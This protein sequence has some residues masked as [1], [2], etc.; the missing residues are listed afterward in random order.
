MSETLE[1]EIRSVIYRNDESGYAVVRVEDTGGTLVTAVGCLPHIAPGETLTAQGRWTSHPSHGEQFS[2]HKVRRRLPDTRE[3]VLAYLS[4]G[5]IRGVGKATALLIVEEFGAEALQVLERDPGQLA[6]VK[7]LSASRAKQISESFAR[8]IGIRKLMEL[9]AGHGIQPQTAL[10]LTQAYGPAAL[11]RITENPYLMIEPEFGVEF[12]LADA[13]AL[14]GGMEYDDLRRRQA[15]LLYQLYFNMEVGHTYLPHKKL[16]DST[17]Q[18]L[19]EEYPAVLAPALEGLLSKRR[20]MCEDGTPEASSRCYLHELYAAETAVAAFFRQKIAQQPAAAA[21]PELTGLLAEIEAGSGMTYAP[22]QRKAVLLAAQSGAMLL[23]GGPGTGKTTI[24]KAMLSLFARR[25]WRFALAAPT[26]RAAKRLGEVTGEAAS[27]IHR[28]LEFGPD[29][30]TGR[31]RFMRDARRPLEADVVVVDET[32]MVDILLL[33]SLVI[34]LKPETRLILVGDPDQLPPVGPGQAFED[35][36]SSE[37]IPAVRLTEIF[38]QGRES[39]IV[40]GAHSVNRGEMPALKNDYKDFFFL[41]RGDAAETV[42]TVVELCAER[43]PRNLGL[44]PSQIQVLTPTRKGACGTA[45]LNTVL[46]AA[47]NP[48][49]EDKPEKRVGDTVFRLG[50]RVMQI[51]NNYNL[52]RYDAQDGDGREEAGVGV[53]NGEIGEIAKVDL[54]ASLLVVRF[55]EHWVDYPFEALTELEPAYALTVHKAQGSE[56]AAV[57]LAS[58]RGPAPLMTRR[59]LYTAMTRAR[60]WLIAVGDAS[61]VAEMTRN[62]RTSRRYSALCERITL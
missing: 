40:M 39:G 29:P 12:P 27:T 23:T 46:Q 26:G 21:P 61:V 1:G 20:V 43:L 52:V 37:A 8:Q 30:D 49:G 5:V 41:R 3:A 18:L 9:L 6:R 34:A 25:Q 59:V 45:A 13:M 55:D 60:D 53:F 15:A 4:G 17:A 54:R 33:H 42:A 50:D 31:M 48:P 62:N 58:M 2:V 14:S 32:S 16:L 51:R 22:D 11:H 36:V 10:R 57:V 47:L 28:L 35:C 56:Y 19:G 44:E 24:V 38:R 7:G